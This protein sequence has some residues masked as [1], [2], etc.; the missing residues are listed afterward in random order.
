MSTSLTIDLAAVVASLATFVTAA[1]TLYQVR[2]K[3]TQWV[4]QAARELVE[5]MQ[6]QVEVLSVHM[7]HLARENAA[8]RAE[9]AVVKA[10]RDLWKWGATRLAKQLEAH[11][12]DPAWRYPN[13]NGNGDVSRDPGGHRVG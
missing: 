8:L 12:L 3:T 11:G 5:P 1:V 6:R 9:L 4:V 7:A 2:S 10:E 13:G